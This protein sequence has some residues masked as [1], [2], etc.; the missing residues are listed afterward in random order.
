MTTT[1]T[2]TM[3]QRLSRARTQLLLNQPF[4][5]A[6]SLRLKLEEGT[7]RTWSKRMPAAEFKVTCV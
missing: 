1:T 2:M 7:T 5:D 3:A 6:L 4:F